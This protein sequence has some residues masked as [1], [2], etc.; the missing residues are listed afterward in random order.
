MD[1]GQ[2]IGPCR[3][4]HHLKTQKDR[5]CLVHSVA[6]TFLSAPRPAARQGRGVISIR[7]RRS[8]NCVRQDTPYIRVSQRPQPVRQDPYYLTSQMS[9][10]TPSLI[11]RLGRTHTIGQRLK[12]LAEPHKA[13]GSVPF[14]GLAVPP[15]AQTHAGHNSITNKKT[16][17]QLWPKDKNQSRF[18]MYRAENEPVMTNH[19]LGFISCRLPLWIDAKVS[20]GLQLLL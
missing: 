5:P 8:P 3:N 2:S 12:R 14:M 19:L 11:V 1:C 4:L 6:L 9:P 16:V 10:P 18:T 7:L 17:L 20:Q 15:A 13:A